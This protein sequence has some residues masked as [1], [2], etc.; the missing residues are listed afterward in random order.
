[1]S[2]FRA[3]LTAHVAKARAASSK[4]GPDILIK[5]RERDLP[6]ACVYIYEYTQNT[7]RMGDS[8]QRGE[9]FFYKN[10]V[11]RLPRNRDKNSVMLRRLVAPPKIRDED[12]DANDEPP[13]Q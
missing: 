4:S 13:R 8:P 9:F 6:S 1:M 5:G 12:E 7:D 3:F 10:S 2:V 11:R